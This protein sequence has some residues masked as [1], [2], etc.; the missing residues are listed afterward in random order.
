MNKIING[1][2]YDTETATLKGRY[3]YSNRGS[4]EFWKEEL[5]QKKTGE[6]FL[7]GEGHALSKYSDCG[8]GRSWG[9]EKIIP[10]TEDEAKKWAEKY[11][12]ADEYESLFGKVDE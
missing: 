10:Y 7:Y 4:F 3:D 8:G 1:K 2:R 6:W 9:I 12:P 5:Y 11:M